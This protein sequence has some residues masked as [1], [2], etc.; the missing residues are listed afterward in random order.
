MMMY[1]KSCCWSD[2]AMQVTSRKSWCVL[3]SE[4]SFFSSGCNA[5]LLLLLLLIVY[6][7]FSTRS[8][9]LYY[10]N[11]FVI[12]FPLSSSLFSPQLVTLPT[13]LGPRYVPHWCVRDDN[14]HKRVPPGKA[15]RPA[16]AQLR[17]LILHR[18]RNFYGQTSSILRCSQYD[19]LL[20]NGYKTEQALLKRNPGPRL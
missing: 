1:N 17:R 16:I 15:T 3:K 9:Y 19:T 20:P 5:L 8:P 14:V 13:R 10:K 2:C 18:A 11:P 4:M 7:S 12:F 6:G